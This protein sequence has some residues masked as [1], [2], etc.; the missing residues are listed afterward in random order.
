M[1]YITNAGHTG[2]PFYLVKKK[3]SFGIVILGKTESAPL[4]I[5]DS[6]QYTHKQISVN[7]YDMCCIQMEF[8]KQLT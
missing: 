8:W 2:T 1:L 3:I 5:D 4:G 7:E 6:V